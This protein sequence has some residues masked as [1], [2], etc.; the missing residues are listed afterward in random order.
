M[1][2]AKKDFSPKLTYPELAHP[3]KEVGG[4]SASSAQRFQ[5][6]PESAARSEKKRRGRSGVEEAA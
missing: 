4:A 2:K 5:R 3:E 1:A 6:L